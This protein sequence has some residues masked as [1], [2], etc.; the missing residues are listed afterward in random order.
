MAVEARNWGM[1]REDVLLAQS[2]GTLQQ[3]MEGGKHEGLRDSE[4]SS[5]SGS[6]ST[7]ASSSV[8][9]DGAEDGEGLHHQEDDILD[10]ESEHG[11]VPGH[12]AYAEEVDMAEVREGFADSDDEWDEMAGAIGGD[13]SDDDE[14]EVKT[15]EDEVTIPMKRRREK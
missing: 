8:S 13:D 9:N 11:E 6:S 1:S 4:T 2:V 5:T 7:S 3:W 10:D 14:L 15:E 12:V